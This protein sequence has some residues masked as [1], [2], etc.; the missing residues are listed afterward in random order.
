M[1]SKSKKINKYKKLPYKKQKRKKKSEEER[2]Q[3]GGGNVTRETET[4]E[5]LLQAKKCW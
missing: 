1:G 4:G 2:I 3:T 5:M